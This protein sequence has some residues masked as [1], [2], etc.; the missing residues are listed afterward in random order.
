VNAADVGRAISPRDRD[1]IV[2]AI[3]ILL[4]VLDRLKEGR[5]WWLRMGMN[6][7]ISALRAFYDEN[8][9]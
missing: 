8:K 3:W 2:A 1:V 9:A 5:P 7:L 6:T 4:P